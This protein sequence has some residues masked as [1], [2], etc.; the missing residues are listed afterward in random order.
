MM[1]CDLD[2]LLLLDRR[3]VLL[4]IIRIVHD[5]PVEVGILLALETLHGKIQAETA[6]IR[7]G[8]HHH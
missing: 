3:P 8:A 4:R 5:D 2:S 6:V 7:R 1:I